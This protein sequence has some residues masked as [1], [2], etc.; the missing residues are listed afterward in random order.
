MCRFTLFG[1][2]GCWTGGCWTVGEVAG[3]RAVAEKAGGSRADSWGAGAGTGEGREILPGV[4]AVAGPVVGGW[5]EQSSRSSMSRRLLSTSRS[6]D[7]WSNLSRGVR[8]RA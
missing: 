6:T 4:A 8:D 2:G 5:M 3:V 7:H 1:R